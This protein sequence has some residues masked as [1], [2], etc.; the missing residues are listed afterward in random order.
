MKLKSAFFAVVLLLLTVTVCAAQSPMGFS[1]TEF[2]DA[3][4][5][6]NDAVEGPECSYL[7]GN[8]EDGAYILTSITSGTLGINMEYSGKQITEISLVYQYL[9]GDEEAWDAVF[10]MTFS[11]LATLG[12]ASKIKSVSDLTLQDV[13]DMLDEIK[14]AYLLIDQSSE[15]VSYWGFRFEKF[16]QEKD[17]Y[18]E[19][20]LSVTKG[21]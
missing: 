11:T 21:D 14:A 18:E 7:K 9:S 19:G 4:V 1:P 16:S 5:L 3:F 15:P 8:E 17:G 20:L 6:I 13:V 2:Y 10:D 12:A